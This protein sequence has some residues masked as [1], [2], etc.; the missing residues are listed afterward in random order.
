MA[1]G[2]KHFEWGFKTGIFVNCDLH[3]P[4]VIFLSASQERRGRYLQEDTVT[5]AGLRIVLTIVRPNPTTHA[6]VTFMCILYAHRFLF[7]RI[8][9]PAKSRAHHRVTLNA[10]TNRQKSQLDDGWKC[11]PRTII[12]VMSHILPLACVFICTNQSLGQTLS[13]LNVKFVCIVYS[14][15]PSV[16]FLSSALH[17]F[18][19]VH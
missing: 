1:D 14:I 7:L 17:T 12:I 4:R 10:S 3:H 18:T 11:I 15:I 19:N 2:K 16:F 5:N 8:S 13:Q 9:F 6:P